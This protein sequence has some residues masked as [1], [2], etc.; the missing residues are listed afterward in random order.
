MQSNY[1]RIPAAQ[2][3]VIRKSHFSLKKLAKSSSI[4]LSENN[5][6]V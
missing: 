1:K 4:L 6:A 3:R 2:I 5:W